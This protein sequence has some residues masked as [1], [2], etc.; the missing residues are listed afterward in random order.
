MSKKQ[1]LRTHSY[2]V[3]LFFSFFFCGFAHAQFEN[4]SLVGTI[5]DPSGAVVPEATIV[6]LNSA[7]GI[8]ST[9]T[10]N[11]SGDYEVVSL[12]V[13]TY[14]ITASAPGFASAV[15]GRSVYLSIHRRWISW[16]GTGLR[17]WSFSRPDR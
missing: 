2:W 12:R 11:G 15:A 3:A 9:V 10:S 16:I 5:H 14:R 8:Q 4:G 1:K 13:G 17:K 6:V 7:T